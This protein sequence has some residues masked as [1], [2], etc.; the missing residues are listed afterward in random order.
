[1]YLNR[2]HVLVFNPFVCSLFLQTVVGFSSSSHCPYSYAVLLT[3]YECSSDVILLF[4]FK[5]STYIAIKHLRLCASNHEI[6]MAEP[7]DKFCITYKKFTPSFFDE[8]NWRHFIKSLLI[9]WVYRVGCVFV[10]IEFII[11]RALRSHNY[12]IRKWFV[13]FVCFLSFSTLFLRFD[14]LHIF[15][16]NH[17]C[18]FTLVL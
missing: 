6:F 12:I 3:T 1:M 2:H 5:S 16:L 7:R 9:N 15:R 14:C 11:M 17:S 13:Y 4:F 18:S 8:E 10:G